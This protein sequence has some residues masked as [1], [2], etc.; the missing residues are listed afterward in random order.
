MKKRGAPVSAGGTGKKLTTK[1]FGLRG[2]KRFPIS[3]NAALR[4]LLGWG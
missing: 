2:Y 1:Q 4:F 3:D